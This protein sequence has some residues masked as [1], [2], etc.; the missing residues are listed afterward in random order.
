[1]EPGDGAAQ[2]DD[3][4]H[5]ERGEGSDV[6]IGSLFSPGNDCED[7]LFSLEN[8]MVKDMKAVKAAKAA[9]SGFVRSRTLTQDLPPDLGVTTDWS[10]NPMT[11]VD[12]ER[13]GG[14]NQLE[15]VL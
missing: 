11:A 6:D 14:G 10:S 5:K 7:A 8:P 4:R 3:S 2:L 9:G 15:A 12:Q 13:G 1:M